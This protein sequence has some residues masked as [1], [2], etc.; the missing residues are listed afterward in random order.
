MTVERKMLL[1]PHKINEAVRA[2]EVMECTC[3]R[4]GHVWITPKPPKYCPKCNSPYWNIPRGQKR[5]PKKGVKY[6]PRVKK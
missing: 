1:P 6:K 3:L 2:V 5:G 4:C